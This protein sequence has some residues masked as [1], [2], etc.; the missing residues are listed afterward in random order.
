MFTYNF[1]EQDIYLCIVLGMLQLGDF[2]YLLTDFGSS[3]RKVGLKFIFDSGN[4]PL[5]L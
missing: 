3:F 5:F 1:Q 4:D 2:T